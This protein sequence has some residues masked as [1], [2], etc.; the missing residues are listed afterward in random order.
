MKPIVKP[1]FH[2]ANLFARIDKKV[3]T[4]PTCSRRTFS[5]PNFNQSRH[6]I[7][8]FASRRARKVAKG[9]RLKE[10]IPI[11]A[12]IL[13]HTPQYRQNASYTDLATSIMS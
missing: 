6:Q 1:I 2:L 3:G 4:L 11:Y 8:V 7:L 9:K 5:P 10:T 13:L 12:H